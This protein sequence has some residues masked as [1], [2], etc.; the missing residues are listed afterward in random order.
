LLKGLKNITEQQLLAGCLKGKLD[1]QREFF[2]RFSGKMLSLSRRY[3]R[4]LD[5]AKDILQD[6]F[7]KVFQHLADFKSAGSLEGWI[8]KTVVHTALNFYRKSAYKSE[9]PGLE[10]YQGAVEVDRGALDNLNEQDIIWAIAT[11]PDGYRM[12]FNL[13]AIEGYS[14]KEIAEMLGIDESTSRSQLF[15]ARNTLKEILLKTQ[16][17]LI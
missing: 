4:N 10:K 6:A 5:D 17:I 1:Y 2:N 15:K 13:Y 7:I 14:H 11:L 3:A 16:N 12:V 8:R 9:K